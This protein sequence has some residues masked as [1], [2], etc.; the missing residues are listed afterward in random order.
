MKLVMERKVHVAKAWH[1]GVKEG[2]R[3]KLRA[4]HTT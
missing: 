4:Q 2:E 1:E 3:E